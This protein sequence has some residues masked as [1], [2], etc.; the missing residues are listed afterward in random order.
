MPISVC[1]AEVHTTMSRAEDGSFRVYKNL[2]YVPKLLC[3]TL[4]PRLS[5]VSTGA[6]CT[7]LQTRFGR[8]STVR[9]W[10]TVLR[11]SLLYQVKNSSSFRVA[12]LLIGLPPAMSTTA[13]NVDV[14]D[15]WYGW[16]SRANNVLYKHTRVIPPPSQTSPANPR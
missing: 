13:P 4:A 5:M 11:G 1:D 10:P 15:V 6:K 3:F 16:N 12:N 9:E 7:V 14:P 8:R 2:W